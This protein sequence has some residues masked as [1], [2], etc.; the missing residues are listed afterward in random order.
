M[1]APARGGQPDADAL[2]SLTGRRPTLRKA[3][4]QDPVLGVSTPIGAAAPT[5]QNRA[6]EAYAAV[7]AEPPAALAEVPAASASPVKRKQGGYYIHDAD[8]ARAQAAFAH[9]RLLDGGFD[10]WSE[11]QVAALMALTEQK[12]RE[13]NEGRPFPLLAGKMKSGRPAGS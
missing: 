7:G 1:T 8:L 13:H 11:F 12:E 9:T 5:V 4:P 3:P 2:A 10:T 6:R